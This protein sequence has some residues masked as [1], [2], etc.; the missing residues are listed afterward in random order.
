MFIVGMT[1]GIGSGKSTVA[2]YFRELGVP[3]YDADAEAHA[4]VEP[5]QPA[6]TRV[7]A[8]F[9]DHL[10]LS[11]GRLDRSALRD[12]VFADAHKRQRLESIL[13]P[14]VREALSRRVASTNAPYCVLAIPLLFEANQRDL[15]QRV[16]VVDTAVERQIERT[17]SRPGM[18][19]AMI[20]QIMAAQWSRERR[21]RAA[22]DVIE[23]NGTLEQLRSRVNELHQSYL[24]LAAQARLPYR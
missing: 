3:V 18:T 11:D 2:A 21:L 8:E 13:H 24:E 4:L 19:R 1:G 12:A 22:D 16:L 15:V 23:N 7:I 14:L 6:L 5:G 10:L 20:E 9:G 17:L